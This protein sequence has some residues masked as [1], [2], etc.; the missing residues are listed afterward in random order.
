[1]HAFFFSGILEL[2]P[3]AVAGI[4]LALT[5]VT[6]VSEAHHALDL[7]PLASHFFR[8]RLWLTTA[9]VTREWAA[10]HRKRHAKCDTP[11][12]P[13]SPQI[14][15]LNR[16]LCADWRLT[17]RIDTLHHDVSAPPGAARL[18]LTA[19]LFDRRSQTRIARREFEASVATPTADSAA[20]VTA[21]SL[22]V[23]Q[24]FD[25]LLPWL[26]DE[27]QAAPARLAP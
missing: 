7:H 2:S 14:L 21:L 15:G 6:I 11:E 13:H 26:E 3:W 4:T 9:M 18:A 8:F 5:H 12:N 27:L 17:L 1:M 20:A 23:T 19:E 25:V 16:A 24:V 10:V 22:C